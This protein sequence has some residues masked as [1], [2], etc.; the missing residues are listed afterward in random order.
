[1]EKSGSCE[2]IQPEKRKD[3]M[4]G[5]CEMWRIRNRSNEFLEVRVRI[6]DKSLRY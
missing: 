3:K 1:M 2:N 4:Y 6:E 5:S